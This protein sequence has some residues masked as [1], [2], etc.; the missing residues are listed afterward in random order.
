MGGYTQA[1]MPTYSGSF[2]GCFSLR[3]P[4]T[5]VTGIFYPAQDVHRQQTGKAYLAMYSHEC[6]KPFKPAR[7]S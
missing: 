1:D 3:Q 7:L 5:H 6:R 2:S 4:D